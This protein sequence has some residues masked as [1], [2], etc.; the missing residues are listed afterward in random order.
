M[1]RSQSTRS[2]VPSSHLEAARLNYSD[3][4]L[5]NGLKVW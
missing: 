2:D 4:V 3:S 1:E 5:G